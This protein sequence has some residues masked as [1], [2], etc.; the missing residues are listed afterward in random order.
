MLYQMGR[1]VYISNPNLKLDQGYPKKRSRNTTYV[2][3]YLHSYNN[4]VIGFMKLIRFSHP[5]RR[6]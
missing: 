6:G 5:F 4:S 2:G 1:L 3:V